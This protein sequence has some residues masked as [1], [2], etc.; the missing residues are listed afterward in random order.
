MSANR[1]TM[2]LWSCGILL[3]LFTLQVCC[4]EAI[5]QKW[6]VSRAVK[7]EVHATHIHTLRGLCVGCSR[8]CQ[9]HTGQKCH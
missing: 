5:L 7:H 1:G 8:C 2:G 9:L 4:S 3:V 6:V